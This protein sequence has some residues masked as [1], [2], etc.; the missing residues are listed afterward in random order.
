M[1]RFIDDKGRI[2][3]KINIIDFIIILFI[4]S[5]LPMFYFGYD[6]I[7]K[8]KP[9]KTVKRN[10]SVTIDGIIYD[11]DNQVLKNIRPGDIFIGQDGEKMAEIINVSTLQ[12]TRR[13][14]KIGNEYHNIEQNSLFLTL[15]MYGSVKNEDFIFNNT[16]L[17]NKKQI[18]FRTSAYTANI[19]LKEKGKEE[20]CFNRTIQV[21]VLIKRTFPEIASII[22][23]GDKEVTLCGDN[24][25]PVGE[26]ASIISKKQYKVIRL[27]KLADVK[28]TMI[29]EEYPDLIDI[30]LILNLK[31]L[32][33]NDGF[34]YKNSPI[35]IGQYIEFQTLK[36]K[37]DGFVLDLKK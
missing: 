11:P 4:I 19:H 30:E 7:Y 16:S 1:I 31:V 21:K 29:T 32:Q 25:T 13:K 17:S 12:K 10:T 23:A 5:L 28:K 8:E 37:F 18:P 2:F 26:I 35:K 36:Y 34:Y 14:I 22:S 3:G 15:K 20:I 6:L 27:K 33:K 9:I 24:T